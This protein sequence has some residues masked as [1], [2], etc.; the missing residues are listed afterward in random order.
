MVMISDEQLLSQSHAWVKSH[1]GQKQKPSS[2]RAFEDTRGLSGDPGIVPDESKQEHDCRNP[3]E[4]SHT[5][6][7]MARELQQSAASPFEPPESARG[8]VIPASSQ[9][10]HAENAV[11]HQDIFSA[12]SNAKEAQTMSAATTDEPVAPPLNDFCRSLLADLLGEDLPAATA[13]SAAVSGQPHDRHIP[14]ASPSCVIINTRMETHADMEI[15]RAGADNVVKRDVSVLNADREGPQ[16]AAVTALEAG[17]SLP[18]SGSLG[19]R[20][21]LKAG[22]GKKLSMRERIQMLQSQ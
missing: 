19:S 14:E 16:K 21:S 12:R 5:C 11:Q 7:A 18:Y 9:V 3:L 17:S 22:P 4:Q 15:R 13:A 20:G 10:V 8:T 6:G 1:A 2:R